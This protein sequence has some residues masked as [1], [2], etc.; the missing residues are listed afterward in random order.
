[1]L[2]LAPTAK[3]QQA[4]GSV[5][6]LVTDA[7]TK[8]PVSDLRVMI[9][10]TTIGTSTNAEGRY[11]LARVP[12]GQV[13]IRAIRVG[14]QQQV[15]PVDIT[16][17]QSA[18]LDFVM[19]QAA[20]QLTEI[21]TTATGEQRRVELGNAIATIANVPQKVE[22]T[23][24][25]NIADLLT[26]KAPGIVVLPAAM[27]GAAPVVRIRGIGSLA[28]TGSGIT[29]DPIYIIDGVRMNSGTLNLGTGGTRAS[30]LNDLDPNE[31]QDIEVVKGPSAA[32]LYGTDAANGVV[33]IT[34]KRGRA[35]ATQWTWF[36]EQ[37]LVQDNN[38][39]P[40]SYA[41]WGS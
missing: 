25:N 27:T 22:Q 40:A 12:A 34:T 10:G 21:V 32:T 29:N 5:T 35:G 7:G 19:A 31:I 28:T 6:G 13:S 36:G 17:G 14:Y 9:V 1:V 39:Y 38:K 11:T 3:S 20:V 15:K 30:L 2:A 16:A 41:L 37:G 23:A 26:A 8:L 4:Y 24:T 33:V 18:T